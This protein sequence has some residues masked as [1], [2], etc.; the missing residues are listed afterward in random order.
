MFG[1][2]IMGLVLNAEIVGPFVT[3]FVVASTNIHLCYNN[4]QKKYKE[5]KQMISRQWQKHNHLLQNNNLSNIEE[6]TI[7]EDLFWHICGEKSESK[8]KVLQIRPEVYR[9]LRHMVLIL[10]FLFLALC[11]IIFL[12]TTYSVSAVVS[13]IAVF[14]SGKIPGLFFKGLT[15]ENKFSGATKSV[16]MA[17]IEEAVKEYNNKN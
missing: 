13:T 15:T 8:Y 11:A 5:V 10:I 2:I 6:G 9:M 7:P 3:F 1:F 4:L 14:V 16:M 17:K 12:R